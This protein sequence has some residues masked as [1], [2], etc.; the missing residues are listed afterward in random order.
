MECPLKIGLSAAFSA[1]AAWL[2]YRGLEAAKRSR[3]RVKLAIVF[4]GKRKSGKDYCS[5][6]LLALLGDSVGEIGRL[7]GP[8][9][10]A[11]ADEHGLDYN[12]LLTASAYKETHRKS[13]I[14]WGEARRNADSGFFARKIL[15]AAK[16]PVLLV[17][18][19][20]R[21]TDVDFFVRN[22]ETVVRVR[23][24]A[25]EAERKTR[26]WTFA[27]GVDDAESECGLDSYTPWEFN[28]TNEPWNAA[29]VEAQLLEIANIAIAAA[30]AQGP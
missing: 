12:E 7:S 18:D 30:K 9:K 2:V 26:G 13:M 14:A 27:G 29:K 17:S 11:Y 24:A 3:S 19:A 25:S 21:T 15:H 16:A 4:S 20:R 10:R 1:G 5:D 8:L 22:V 28:I 23:V 6:K